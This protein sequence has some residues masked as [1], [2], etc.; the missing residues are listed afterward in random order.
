[1]DNYRQM[2]EHIE[3][4]IAKTTNCDF[5]KIGLVHELRRIADTLDGIEDKLEQ[6]D[7]VA[8]VDGLV[9]VEGAINTFEQN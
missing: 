4:N 3:D 7:V 6:L 5:F 8:Q 1:M 2:M 9:T